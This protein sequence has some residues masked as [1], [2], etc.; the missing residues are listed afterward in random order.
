MSY[1]CE[2]DAF[3][4]ALLPSTDFKCAFSNDDS[5][6]LTFG[7]FPSSLIV[8]IKFRFSSKSTIFSTTL[9]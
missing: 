2:L 7:L 3:D 9:S 6:W 8:F 4:G 1:L 5:I